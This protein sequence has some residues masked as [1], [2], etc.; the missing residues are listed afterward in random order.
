MYIIIQSFYIRDFY[1][2]KKDIGELRVLLFVMLFNLLFG[3]FYDSNKLL[4]RSK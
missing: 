1:L 2:Y 3:T 4:S